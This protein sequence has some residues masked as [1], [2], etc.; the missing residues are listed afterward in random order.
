MRRAP[1]TTSNSA[2]NSSRQEAFGSKG[3]EAL[4]E[5][6]AV[7]TADVTSSAVGARVTVASVAKKLEPVPLRPSEG[8]QPTSAWPT[9]GRR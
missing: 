7:S 9:H 4:V 5:Q 6:P 1:P 8:N 2:K 3:K